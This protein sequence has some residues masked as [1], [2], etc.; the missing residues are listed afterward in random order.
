MSEE[1]MEFTVMYMIGGMMQTIEYYLFDNEHA[2]SVQEL[3]EKITFIE[4]KIKGM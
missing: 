3:A 2:L 1:D 4:S